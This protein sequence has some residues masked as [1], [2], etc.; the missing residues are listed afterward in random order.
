MLDK[1]VKNVPQP[2]RETTDD[3]LKLL[4]R[5]DHPYAYFYN[6]MRYGSVS[7]Y[8]TP[9]QMEAVELSLEKARILR[10]HIRDFFTE[11]PPKLAPDVSGTGTLAVDPLGNIIDLILVPA[12]KGLWRHGFD[13]LTDEDVLKLYRPTKAR[14]TTFIWQGH[15]Y[16]GG[17]YHVLVTRQG[18][19][20]VE[21]LLRDTV[22]PRQPRVSGDFIVVSE[23]GFAVNVRF[24]SVTELGFIHHVRLSGFADHSVQSAISELL[25]SGMTAS[26]SVLVDEHDAHLR[27]I[28]PYVNP[29]L[30][31]IVSKEGLGYAFPN[32]EE[33][34]HPVPLSVAASLWLAGRVPFLRRRLLDRVDAYLRVTKRVSLSSYIL[35]NLHV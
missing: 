15:T 28:D 13:V 34:H 30:Y 20:I 9:K 10:S 27:G 8:V 19:F 7:T 14:G 2:V 17:I 6:R 5:G 12:A 22:D 18:R 1:W 23:D 16:K 35:E 25:R 24:D 11:L 32:V 21:V 4:Q 26:F 29:M 33:T 31:Q 3:L